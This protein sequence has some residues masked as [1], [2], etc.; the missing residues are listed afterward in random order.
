MAEKIS[1]VHGEISLGNDREV[2]PLPH[3]LLYR[4]SGRQKSGTGANRRGVRTE[5]NPPA[6]GAGCRWSHRHD[7]GQAR[8]GQRGGVQSSA[9]P[10]HLPRSLHTDG[11][12]RLRRLAT[13]RP[14]AVQSGPAHHQQ[15][16]DDVVRSDRR[17]TLITSPSRPRLQRDPVSCS[18]GLFL[19][20][21]I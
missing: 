7:P 18:R 9:I 17:R 6:E 16:A 14:R 3:S 15:Y 5:G 21:K 4:L 1:G 10:R 11:C 2:F 8:R 20:I 12:H 13:N 19:L